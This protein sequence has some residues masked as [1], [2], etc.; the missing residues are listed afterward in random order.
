MHKNYPCTGRVF[1]N[2]MRL[3]IAMLLTTGSLMAQKKNVPQRSSAKASPKKESLQKSWNDNTSSAEVYIAQ[4]SASQ[5]LP[6][7]TDGV[8]QLDVLPEVL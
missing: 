8:L 5:T 4:R 1:V 2:A 3:S 7:N 6:V